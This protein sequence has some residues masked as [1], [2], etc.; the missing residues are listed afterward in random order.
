MQEPHFLTANMARA[1]AGQ[2]MSSKIQR[3][4]MDGGG[5]VRCGTRAALPGWEAYIHEGVRVEDSLEV[6][7]EIFGEL[8]LCSARLLLRRSSCRS[9]FLFHW[10]GG[11]AGS[12]QRLSPQ[13]QRPP[14]QMRTS[15]GAVLR[16]II[17]HLLTLYYFTNAVRT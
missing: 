4:E 1:Q 3:G 11:G 5:G 12:G 9:V 14:R 2:E 8:L 10:A 16:M 17:V 13:V 15:A 6:V 7:E